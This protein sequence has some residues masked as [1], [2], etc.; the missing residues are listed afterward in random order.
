[1]R[2]QA[3]QSLASIGKQ[4]SV[5]VPA[6]IQAL[7]DTGP[8]VRFLAINAQRRFGATA[9]SAVPQ[10]LIALKDANPQVSDAAT[11]AL[12]QIA[13]QTVKQK[14]SHEQDVDRC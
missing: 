2:I 8:N 11:H 1:M 6:L 13:P 7:G 5:V 10:L 3:I 12:K 9:T 4:P 14:A